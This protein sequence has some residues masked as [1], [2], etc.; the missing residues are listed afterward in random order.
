MKQELSIR[1]KDG[2]FYNMTRFD[3]VRQRANAELKTVYPS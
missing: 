2:E 3:A 1:Y